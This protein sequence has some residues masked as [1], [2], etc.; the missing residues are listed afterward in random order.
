[1]SEV[2]GKFD[3]SIDIFSSRKT[4][5]LSSGLASYFCVHYSFVVRCSV[6]VLVVQ[7]TNNVRATRIRNA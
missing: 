1:M 5:T 4:D 2:L 3:S 7:P 6:V